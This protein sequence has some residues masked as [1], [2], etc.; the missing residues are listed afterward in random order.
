MNARLDGGDCARIARRT[1][2]VE[3]LRIVSD[4]RQRE[5]LPLQPLRDPRLAHG[6][7]WQQTHPELDRSS[8]GLHKASAW[9]QFYNASP[10]Q[11][12]RWQI[13]ALR[14]LAEQ[15]GLVRSGL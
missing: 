14:Q 3:V 2:R 12:R 4:R 15:E 13:T 8:Y 7:G 11:C 10:E 6:V 1:E 5:P 9:A